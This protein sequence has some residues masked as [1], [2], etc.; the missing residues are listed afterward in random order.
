[1]IITAFDIGIKNFAFSCEE[2]D[3][4]QIPNK[5]LRSFDKNGKPN[6]D[7]Q[8]VL[9]KVY[10]S[11]KIVYADNIDIVS[12]LESN[13]KENDMNIFKALHKILD[14]HIKIW[15][16]TDVF[17]IEQ[18]MGYGKNSSN[19]KALKIAHQC[20]SYFMTIYGPFKIIV[21]FSSSYKTRVLGCSFEHRSKYKLRKEFSI[22]LA[23][24]ILNSR[25][26]KFIENFKKLKKRDDI[27]DCIL[28]IQAYKILFLN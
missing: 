21:E 27:A 28:M 11:G 3:N 10:N 4:T 1:M 6:K 13:E 8:L 19:I 15:D 20:I 17:L 23:E 18:Q 12:T 14:S 2:I 25:N 9:D 24:Y 16:N 26:D 7:Y 22:N 5:I